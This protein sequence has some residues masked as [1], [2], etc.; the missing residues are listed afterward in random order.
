MFCS[1]GADDTRELL[2]VLIPLV[3]AVLYSLGLM[4]GR[5]GRYFFFAGL[6]C[7]LFFVAVRGITLET[8]PLTEKHD[9]ISFMAFSTGLLFAYLSIKHDL[10]GSSLIALPLIST[11][12]VIA[13]FHKPIDTIAPLLRTPWFYIHS[14]LFFGSYGFFGVSFC[15][16]LYFL[17]TRDRDFESLQYRTALSGWVMYTVALIVG[18]VWFYIAYGTY[19]IWTPRELWTTLAWF[20]FGLYLHARMMKGFFGIPAAGIGVA[21]YAV[22]LFAYFGVGTVI[23]SPPTQF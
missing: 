4:E 22:L 18:S 7:H 11:I 13:V 19:W 12:L 10:K 17:A 8:I 2:A 5:K 20:Y 15:A 1:A 21:G 23:P 9:T 14:F 16:G 6:L 3:P